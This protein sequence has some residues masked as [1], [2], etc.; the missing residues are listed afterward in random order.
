MGV[1]QQTR[2]LILMCSLMLFSL[3]HI[4]RDERAPLSITM[5]RELLLLHSEEGAA[6]LQR[7]LDPF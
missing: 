3:D 6:D 4:Y 5:E 1:P 2:S 7:A